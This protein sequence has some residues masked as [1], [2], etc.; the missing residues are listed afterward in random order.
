MSTY[1]VTFKKNG[2]LKRGVLSES[3]YKIYNSDNS[4]S[5][6][7]IHP[8]QVIMETFYNQAIGKNG[9]SKTLLLG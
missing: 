3:Q 4:V 6:L 1:Y 5:D 2:I 9:S 8:S 7:E